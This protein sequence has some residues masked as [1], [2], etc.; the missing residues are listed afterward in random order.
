MISII[1]ITWFI[2]DNQLIELQDSQQ[3]QA[4]ILQDERNMQ[5][6]EEQEQAIQQLEVCKICHPFNC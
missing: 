5:M 2:A 3:T 4:Q 6:M 1:I